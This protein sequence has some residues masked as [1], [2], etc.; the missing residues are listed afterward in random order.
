MVHSKPSTNFFLAVNGGL[1]A[2]FFWLDSPPLTLLG[3]CP[4]FVLWLSHD[5][6]GSHYETP[7][8]YDFHMTIARLIMKRPN[9]MKNP[10]ISLI[11]MTI[12]ISKYLT[13]LAFVGR[14][15]CFC[16]KKTLFW[17][18]CA[19]VQ[20]RLELQW[21][22]SSFSNFAL[23]S[24]ATFWDWRRCWSRFWY[25]IS[26]LNWHENVLNTNLFNYSISRA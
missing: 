20:S 18:I 14:I 10:M 12:S 23:S 17:D 24:L 2:T 13:F 1:S 9:R 7:Q 26:S 11:K 25:V 4:L 19:I 8:L 3:L 5:Y 6:S 21:A 22:I 15:M 16:S